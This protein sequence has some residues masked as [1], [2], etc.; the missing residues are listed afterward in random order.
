MAAR[1]GTAIQWNLLEATHKA[2]YSP[3]WPNYL[4]LNIVKP[5]RTFRSNSGISLEI[6]MISHTFQDQAAKVFNNL[7]L[8]TR[9]CP[10][11]NV[12]RRNTFNY[13]LEKD[14]SR[15]DHI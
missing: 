8:E 2:I 11:F 15:L 10:D 7:P 3:D 6:P 5:T 1:K 13:L 9:N 12:F 14:K 4:T